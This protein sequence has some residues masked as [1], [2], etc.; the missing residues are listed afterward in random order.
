MDGGTAGDAEI[1]LSIHSLA[2]WDAIL[3]DDGCRSFDQPERSMAMP[4]CRSGG[5][6]S[7]VG[8]RRPVSERRTKSVRYMLGDEPV[9]Y[10]RND[11]DY[12]PNREPSR[13]ILRSATE[14]T[15]RRG[16]QCL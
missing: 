13:G 7:E 9:N 15:K 11:I 8:S 12:S 5:N 10:P 2:T 16:E 6:D 3:G 4:S 14:P 1:E